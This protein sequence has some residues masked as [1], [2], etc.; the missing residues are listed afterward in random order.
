MAQRVGSLHVHELPDNKDIE[1]RSEVYQCNCGREFF[2]EENKD[3]GWGKSPKKWVELDSSSFLVEYD[4][5]VA[6]QTFIGRATSETVFDEEV[7][8]GTGDVQSGGDSG[9]PEPT[10]GTTD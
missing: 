2:V 6:G 1:I 3:S 7:V 9:S 5:T 8:D 4:R 10:S